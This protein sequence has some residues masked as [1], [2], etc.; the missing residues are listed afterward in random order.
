MVNNKKIVYKG[1]GKYLKLPRKAIEVV[2]LNK[3]LNGKVKVKKGN[4]S[5]RGEEC[6][7]EKNLWAL[8]KVKGLDVFKELKVDH[9]SWSVR[10]GKM[11]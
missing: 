9:Y 4:F 7:K 8:K 3:K 1:K 2:N 6:S 5:K 10:I 11:V